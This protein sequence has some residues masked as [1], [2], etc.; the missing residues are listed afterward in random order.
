MNA[1]Q[2]YINEHFEG[3]QAAFS[4]ATGLHPSNI[5]LWISGDRRPD[6]K[7]A[8]AIEA[9]TEG[10]IPVSYWLHDHTAPAPDSRPESA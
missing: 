6:L 4:R 5:S 9:A 3:S 1:L 7:S 10:E 2:A 8:V